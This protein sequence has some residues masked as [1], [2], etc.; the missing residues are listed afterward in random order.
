VTATTFGN[1]TGASLFIASK[2]RGTSAAPTA[3]LN[4]DSLAGFLARGFGTTTFTG[5][6]GGMF[7]NATENWTDTAQG[8]RLN[9][10]TTINGTT[11]PGTRMTIDGFGNVGIGTFGPNGM[12]EVAKT[13][14]ADVL[15]SSFGA[16]G[17][18]F[19][20]RGAN[21][22][23]LAPTATVLG[24]QLGAFSASGFNVTTGFNETSGMAAYAA[25]NFTDTAQG[26][27]L[28]FFATPIASN[29]AQLYMAIMP[30]G[31]VG[32]NPLQFDVN[33]FPIVN[34]KLQVYGDIRVGTTGTNGCIKNFAG[35][36][37]V[38]TCS[39]DRRLKKQIT[40]F[41]PMLEKV[42]ALQPVHYFWRSDEFPNRHLGNGQNSGLIAQDVEQ[43]LPELVDT[44]GDGYK[45]VDYSKL[46]L[47]TI[48]AVKELKAE[49]DTLKAQVAALT[50][51][52][53][54]DPLKQRVAELERLIEE[55]LAAKK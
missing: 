51:Q 48:Q 41:A 26:T 53:E 27:A 6:R 4:G 42:A 12:L 5:T 16:D 55:L 24:N 3:I 33:G 21:G 38:G 49:N 34:D 30:N 7:V 29:E 32:I 8:T 54:N 35:T 43:I 2:A 22:T 46:P 11:T 31:N 45:A 13:G 44:D 50:Q 47:L 1:N 19:K 10:N 25:E 9:F 39:S 15:A 14:T 23:L 37:I 40:P 20:A 28:A 36:G 52:V 17:S 18:S